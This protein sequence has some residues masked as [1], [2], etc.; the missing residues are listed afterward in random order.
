[1]SGTDGPAAGTTPITLEEEFGEWAP[2]I[3]ELRDALGQLSYPEGGARAYAEE[4]QACL[5]AGLLLAALTLSMSLLELTVLLRVF[6][7]ERVEDPGRFQADLEEEK[8]PFCYLL[9]LLHEQGV[10]NEREV[11]RA[12]WLYRNVRIPV[13]HGLTSR[14]LVNVDSAYDYGM[15]SSPLDDEHVR[16]A[17]FEGVVGEVGEVVHILERV[18]A[19]PPK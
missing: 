4:V 19:K 1:M 17:A 10:L 11:E 6:E 9:G 16:G 18:C 12:T 2:V 13:Q 7:L 15:I 14:L 3:A 5:D 8:H